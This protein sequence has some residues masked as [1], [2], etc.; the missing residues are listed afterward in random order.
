[1]GAMGKKGSRTA[2]A[3]RF[4]ASWVEDRTGAVS[5]LARF[6]NHP[7]PK[8]GAW[9]YAL[10]TATLFLM[11]LQFL[12][13]ILLLF[14]YV[15]TNDHAWNSIHYIMNEAYFGQLIRGIHYWSANFLLA[16]IGLH[17]AQVFLSGAYKAPRE[18]NWV[19]GVTLLLLTLG[20]AFTG[21]ALRWDQDGFWATVVGIK[22]G[23][24]SPFVGSAVTHFLLG[25][26][27]AG[28]ATLSRF[29]AL[30]VW[31]LPALIAPLVLLHGVVLVLKHGVFGGETEYRDRIAR[32]H[33]RRRL[34]EYGS[35]EEEDEEGSHNGRG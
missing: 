27:V 33:E 3:G 10:G 8:R 26:D 24:Y 12:T 14:Y 35:H 1:M 4:V 29:F 22:I 17:M 5:G 16:F 34:E 2:E 6:L 15:P 25:G 30:H 21:Y 32:L 20:V 28:P 18:V 11:T 9:M 13:G 31:V 19:L 7:A 23:S